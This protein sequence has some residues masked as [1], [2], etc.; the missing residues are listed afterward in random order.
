MHVI[1]AGS[2]MNG[3]TPEYLLLFILAVL[4]WLDGL[5]LDSNR[6]ASIL[7]HNVRGVDAGCI[8]GLYVVLNQHQLVLKVAQTVVNI[9]TK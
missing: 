7:G 5:R 9:S 4:E 8:C 3:S 6:V 2:D 1:I